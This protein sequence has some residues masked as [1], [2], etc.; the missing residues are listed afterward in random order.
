MVRSPLT[1]LKVRYNR[2]NRRGP[3]QRRSHRLPFSRSYGKPMEYWGS[4]SVAAVGTVDRVHCGPA[5]RWLLKNIRSA[6][7]IHQDGGINYLLL[8]KRTTPVWNGN[9]LSGKHQGHLEEPR[10]SGRTFHAPRI[11]SI[12]STWL[13]PRQI[14]KRHANTNK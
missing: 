1:I 11:G 5:N 7:V 14:A 6:F 12:Y 4:S 2:E 10:S 9:V 3:F 13:I 8:L